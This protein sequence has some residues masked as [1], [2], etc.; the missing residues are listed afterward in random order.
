MCVCVCEVIKEV[1][2]LVVVSLK[3]FS[4]C[5]IHG[6]EVNQFVSVTC[7]LYD[8]RCRVQTAD[9]SDQYQLWC[10]HVL[11]ACIGLVG[12]ITLDTDASLCTPAPRRPRRPEGL[13]CWCVCVFVCLSCRFLGGWKVRRLEET[14]SLL[15]WAVLPEDTGGI[16]SWWPTRI[17]PVKRC[18][19]LLLERPG[20]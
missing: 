13:H 18:F 17:P 20:L 9:I 5:L 3:P 4:L 12:Y 11:H 1:F 2:H 6:R 16:G 14:P 7:S 19:F 10:C 8:T 15:H